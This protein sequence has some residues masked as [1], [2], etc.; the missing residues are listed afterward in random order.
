ML[1]KS[2][3]GPLSIFHQISCWNHNLFY[4]EK[5]PLRIFPLLLNFPW[6]IEHEIARMRK[7]NRLC[8]RIIPRFPMKAAVRLFFQIQQIS[9]STPVLTSTSNVT[10]ST[11]TFVPKPEDNGKQLLCQAGVDELPKSFAEDSKELLVHCKSA[12]YFI[13]THKYLKNTL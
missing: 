12:S 13:T 4:H 11:L 10:V 6:V 2:H 3:F 7:K 9:V 8:S 5:L 1:D